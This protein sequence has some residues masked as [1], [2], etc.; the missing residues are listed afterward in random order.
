MY[1]LTD[2][3]STNGTLLNGVRMEINAPATLAEGDVILIGSTALR[4][5]RPPGAA[6]EEAEAVLPIVAE[7]PNTPEAPET[8]HAEIYEAADADTTE[9]PQT[10]EISQTAEGTHS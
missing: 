7:T 8:T 3:G 6:P 9:L 5:E 1:R 4:F 10:I 2:V